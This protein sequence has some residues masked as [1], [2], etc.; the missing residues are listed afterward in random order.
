MAEDKD[1]TFSPRYY[2]DKSFLLQ[3]EFRQELKNSKI[4]S[5]FSFLIGD[6]G[7]KGHFF[8]NQFG[9]VNNN[10]NYELNLQSVEGDNY[11]KNHKLVDTSSLIN[12]DNLLI[13]NFD[14][15]WDFKDAELYTSVKVFE[16]LSGIIMT[17]I[18]IFP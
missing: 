10:L 5:D 12:N 4:L 7:T 2:A 1:I 8:Y 18:N 13:S 11:L 16:D 9:N 3:N 17:D 14:L 6:A 15:N